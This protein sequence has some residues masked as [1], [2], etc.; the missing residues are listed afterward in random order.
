[1]P[2]AFGTGQ[3]NP[4]VGAANGVTGPDFLFQSQSAN[5][6]GVPEPSSIT[7]ACTAAGIVALAGLWRRRKA[8]RTA[9]C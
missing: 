6:F 8:T 2:S 7:M 5:N 9:L 1:M 3:Y 4:N